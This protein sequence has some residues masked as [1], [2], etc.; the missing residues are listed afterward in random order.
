[1][2]IERCEIEQNLGQG[3]QHLE[4]LASFPGLP[5]F[6][7]FIHNNTREGK[8]SEKQGKPGSIHHV[9]RRKVDVGGI[10]KAKLETESHTIQDE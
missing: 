9:S 8:T 2:P 6:Y 7:L 10:F 4:K 5:C 3:S 1:M